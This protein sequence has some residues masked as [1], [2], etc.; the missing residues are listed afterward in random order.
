MLWEKSPDGNME[1]TGVANLN[2]MAR[3]G[4]NLMTFAHKSRWGSMMINFIY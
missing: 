3:E 2:K 1:W 4:L